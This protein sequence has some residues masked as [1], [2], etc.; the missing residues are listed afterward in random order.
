M[1]NDILR[2]NNDFTV[3]QKR[4]KK[5]V[6]NQNNTKCCNGSP[7]CSEPQNCEKTECQVRCS[8]IE[9]PL[10]NISDISQLS[11]LLS[12]LG[13]PEHVTKVEAVKGD[14]DGE[15]AFNITGPEDILARITAL[16]TPSSN[17]G[18]EKTP[19]TCGKGSDCCKNGQV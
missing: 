11:G 5:M 19:E 8:T 16:Y 4:E 3:L 2:L 7:K 12:E 14:S 10:S 13:A 9:L 6:E 17:S 1:N 15:Y 18:C